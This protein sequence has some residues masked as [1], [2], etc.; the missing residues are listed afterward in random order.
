M[1]LHII[2]GTRPNFIKIAPLIKAV[3]K[4]SSLKCK[5]IHTGQH[6]DFEMD[7][8]FFDQLDIPRPDVN[9]GV[10]SSSDAHQTGLIMVKYEEYIQSDRPDVIIVLGD[11][12][13]TLSCAL[14][15]VK[16]KIFIAH[17]ESGMR[18]F[19]KRMPE[20]INRICTDVISNVLFTS[21]ETASRNLISEGLSKDKIF[22]VGHNMIDTLKMY[23]KL[24]K[25]RKIL[26]ELGLKKGN[27]AVATIHRQSN[28]D[29]AENLQKILGIYEF[30]QNEIPIVF[31]AHPRTQKRF[32][33]FGLD[34]KHLKNLHFIKPQGY[35][36]FQKLLSEC[37]LIITDSGGVQPESVYLN[38]PC[39]TL[40]ENTEWVE[41]LK[42][43][44]NCLV[45]LELKKVKKVFNNIMSGKVKGV[46][47]PRIWDG[48]TSERIVRILKEVK[49]GQ[50]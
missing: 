48:K 47:Y 31:P 24:I 45:G 14:V 3:K 32:N 30:I 33:E 22:L 25:K 28:V 27:Y 29:N 6:Y 11:V 40:R 39:I 18:S 21:T 7:K 37:K 2:V 10:G 17:I 50:K 12:N 4:Y 20:E 46:W 8:V 9:L 1:K 43:G 42:S 5:I 49:N 38:K 23:S 34:T 16:N 35:L 41:S 26:E 15:G 36:D 13:S 19:D 44:L